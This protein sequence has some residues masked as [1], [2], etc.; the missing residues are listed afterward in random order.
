MHV[1]AFGLVG[2]YGQFVAVVGRDV[3]QQGAANLGR[4]AQP[5]H[6]LAL[7]LR[8]FNETQQLSIHRLCDAGLQHAYGELKRTSGAFRD[9]LPPLPDFEQ[10]A[11]GL[12]DAPQSADSALV[13]MDE[14]R[15]A[16][17]VSLGLYSPSFVPSING[18]LPGQPGE[19]V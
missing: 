17:G 15:I 5:G 12:N 19:Q 9:H 13:L 6:V 14:E 10:I 3:H 11:Q 2:I 1:D 18:A 4:Y 8:V 16:N 7:A